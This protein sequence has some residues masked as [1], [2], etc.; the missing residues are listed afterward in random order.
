MLPV[1]VRIKA[2]P[3]LQISVP[4]G[5]F[6]DLSQ[7]DAGVSANQSVEMPSVLHANNLAGSGNIR[8]TSNSFFVGNL[9]PVMKDNISADRSWSLPSILFFCLH[10]KGKARRA[11]DGC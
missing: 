9:L 1:E 11:N 10:A 2:F 7:K 8:A 4:G 3:D 5:M 6:L